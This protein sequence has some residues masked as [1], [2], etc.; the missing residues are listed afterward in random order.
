M[1]FSFRIHQMSILK[2]G[3][4]FPTSLY[5]KADF[6]PFTPRIHLPLILFI[7]RLTSQEQMQPVRKEKRCESSLV[8][9]YLFLLLF[10]VLFGTFFVL[11]PLF[12]FSS[13][14]LFCF[15]FIIFCR[16]KLHTYSDASN[17]FSSVSRSAGDDD[18]SIKQVLLL[19]NLFR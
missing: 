8:L 4:K 7:A 3:L 17:F 9:V 14:L 11:L 19:F 16:E 13:F 10:F 18:H 5:L 6:T 1:T 12:D 15:G 2:Q